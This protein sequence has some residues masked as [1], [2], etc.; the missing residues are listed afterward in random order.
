MMRTE[1]TRSCWAW[2]RR[3][4][5]DECDVIVRTIVMRGGGA[6]VLPALTMPAVRC[7]LSAGTRRS[8]D[9]S[10]GSITAKTAPQRRGSS[11]GSNRAPT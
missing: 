1:K 4:R 5:H 10:D 9:S 8:N 7:R 11:D 6:V 2:R 3:Q